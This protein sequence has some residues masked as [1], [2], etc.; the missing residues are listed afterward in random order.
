MLTLIIGIAAV[1][2]ALLLGYALGQRSSRTVQAAAEAELARLNA[3]LTNTQVEK[4]AAVTEKSSAEAARAAAEAR[5]EERA[6]SLASLE[7]ERDRLNIALSTAL[8]EKSAVETQRAA[9]I[10]GLRRELDSERAKTAEKL[11]VLEKAE[12]ALTAQF[13][14]LAAKILDE[15]ANTYSESSRKEIGDLL[16]PL[17]EQLTGFRE[18]VE[19]SQIHSAQ[20]VAGLREL[21]GNL[22]GMNQQLSAKAEELAN[23]LRGSAKA[24]GDWGETILRNLLEKAGLRE[25]EQYTF[26]QP[27]AA[28]E[29]ATGQASRTDVILQLP[30][31]RHL[32]VD[33]KVSLTAW[34]DY[35][36]A[37]DDNARKEALKRHLASVR[38][39]VK[40]LAGKQYQNLNGLASP[41]FVVLFI[42]I[43]PAALLA[44]Q[45]DAD[46]WQEAYHSSILIAGPTTLLFVIRIVDNLW[47][48][49]Q[50]ARNVR[51]IAD[52]GAKLYEKFVGFVEDMQTLGQRLAQARASYDA[53]FGKL[54]TGAGNLIGQVEK[55]Q[56]LGVKPS[57]QLPPQLVARALE[58]THPESEATPLFALAAASDSAPES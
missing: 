15:R 3:A 19:Q 46:L 37:A 9:E 16:Q 27:F 28:S 35:S 55:L 23:A 34:T 10:S 56:Q 21:I 33:S 26:Q 42:P 43:E 50:Q 14:S 24:Q 6:H 32:I 30:G 18:K 53:A 48:Q 25:G 11:I 57:K 22:T 39:H 31:G 20:S 13:Q 8:A 17:R 58:S 41:D 54:S 44:L 29:T 52:R 36:S 40:G 1:F 38:A 47:Q 49:E 12:Q 45:S 5:V 51:E 2:V 4:S 7:A